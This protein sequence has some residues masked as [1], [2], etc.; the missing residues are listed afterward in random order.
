MTH[1]SAGVHIPATAG[2][3]AVHGEGAMF[4]RAEVSEAIIAASVRGVDLTLV[5]GDR[6]VGATFTAAEA[7]RLAW[8][9][10]DA[11]DRIDL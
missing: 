1:L 5:E 3:F 8:A 11:A 7:R 9:L 4:P 2:D 6:T 10:V